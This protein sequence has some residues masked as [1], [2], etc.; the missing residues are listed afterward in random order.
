[1]L[2]AHGF[3]RCH[4]SFII[5]VAN[6]VSV[7]SNVFGTSYLIELKDVEEKI[8][9]SRNKYTELKELITDEVIMLS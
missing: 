5:P 8:P 6:I 7:Q 3:F 2:K 1:M 9:L 4:Q